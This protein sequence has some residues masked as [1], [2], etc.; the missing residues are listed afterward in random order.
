MFDTL[1]L[2]MGFFEFLGGA[3]EVR[4][5]VLQ[6]RCHL[7]LEGELLHVDGMVRVGGDGGVGE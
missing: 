2:G 4:A 1:A 7:L 5:E 3:F 6:L